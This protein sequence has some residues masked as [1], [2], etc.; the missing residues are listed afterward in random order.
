MEDKS[1]LA[2]AVLRALQKAEVLGDLVLIGS[3][4]HL[5]YRHYF[6]NAAEVPLVRTLDMDFLIPRQRKIRKKVDIAQL[7]SKM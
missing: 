5:F 3:W 2:L 1:D 6:N 4:C 7:L